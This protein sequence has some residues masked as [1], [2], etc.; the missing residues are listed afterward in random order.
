MM[1]KN[2]LWLTVFV[3]AGMTHSAEAKPSPKPNYIYAEKGTYYYEAAISPRQREAGAAAGE[4][5]G[6]R[7]YGTNSDGEYVLARV[8]SNGTIYEYVYCKKPCRVIR[9]SGGSRIANNN[10]LVASAAFSDAFRGNLRN[11][12]PAAPKPRPAA[13][14]NVPSRSPVGANVI[15]PGVIRTPSGVA[16]RSTANA[17]VYATANGTVEFSGELEGY[18]SAI[19]LNHGNEIQTIYGNIGRMNVSPKAIVT[20]GQV[21]GFVVA[22]MNGSDPE[23]LY[24]VRIA[25]VAIDP[26]AFLGK[27]HA[28]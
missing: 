18:G 25:G 10:M 28:N 1:L 11:T 8:E 15:A 14:V 2:L 22:P 3:A 17:P 21:I 12:N 20:K 26:L 27:D 5:V 23:L 7:Y 9:T 4:A 24:E 13:T 16:I 19:R 6:Y